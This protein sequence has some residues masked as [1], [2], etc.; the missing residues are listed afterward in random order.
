[1]DF[2]NDIG[3]KI[4]ETAKTVTKKSENLVEITKINLSI[5]N[6]EDKIK[7]FFTEIGSELYKNFLDGESYGEYF[8]EKCL[9]IREIENNITALR[10]KQ[11]SIRGHKSCTEC[12]VVI[13]DDVKYCPNC[14]VRASSFEN[15]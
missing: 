14:G 13:D 6:E 1:M 12:N 4:T 11:L 7:R 5:G 9:S 8:D 10:E 3:R 15:D 2:L